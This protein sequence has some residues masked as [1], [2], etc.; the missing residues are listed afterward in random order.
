MAA[1][2]V[3]VVRATINGVNDPTPVAADPTNG[4]S[5][6]NVEGL[7]LT[8]NNTDASSHTVTFVTPATHAGYAVADLVVTLTASAKKSFANFP[9]DAFGRTVTFTANSATVMVSA[10]APAS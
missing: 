9:S 5:V 3:T 7:I 8:L 4:N 6:P 1:T 2:A 10:M